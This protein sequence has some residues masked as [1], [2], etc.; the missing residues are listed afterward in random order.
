MGTGYHM[1]TRAELQTL[2]A[3]CG[4]SFSGSTTTYDTKGIYWVAGATSTVTIGGDKYKVNGLLFVQDADT[5]IFFPAAGGVN[6]TNLNFAGFR[7][8]YWSSSLVESFTDRAYY[9]HFY[10]DDV[11]PDNTYFRYSG[12]TVRPF[13]D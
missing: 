6:G 13:K 11:I 8:Y 5:H 9:L 12:F 3:A 10:S 2:Y 4:G 1:P 7:G